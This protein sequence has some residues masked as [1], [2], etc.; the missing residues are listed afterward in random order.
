MYPFKVYSSVVLVYSRVMQP[1]TL[2]PEY[3][4]HP[5]KKF[6]LLSFLPMANTKSTFCP[7]ES[8]CC[9]HLK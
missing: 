5:P 7:Y 3:F 4:Y 6:H 2:V 9:G 8:A 1:S